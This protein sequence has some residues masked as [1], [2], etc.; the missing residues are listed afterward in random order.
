MVCA[1]AQG[2][3]QTLLTFS[4]GGFLLVN[5][6]GMDLPD[7]GGAGRSV[8]TCCDRAGAVNSSV[9]DVSRSAGELTALA[10]QLR[11]VSHRFV[12]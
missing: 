6:A 9:A 3:N 1:A 8:P 5:H 4:T 11:I 7:T 2:R 12:L 10:E